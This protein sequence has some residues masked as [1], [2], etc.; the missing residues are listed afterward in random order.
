MNISR[1]VGVYAIA[2]LLAGSCIGQTFTTLAYFENG[3]YTFSSLIQGRDG[4]LYGTGNPGAAYGYGDIFKL[5]RDGTLTDLHDF[6]QQPGCTDGGYSGVSLALATDG[7]FYGSASGGTYNLG[8]IFKITPEGAYTVLHSFDG[9]DSSYPG[10]L[11]EAS[12]GNFYGTAGRTV[13]R[14]SPQGQVQTLHIFN[15]SSDGVG[16]VAPL[17]Q[18]SDGYLYGTT[19]AGGAGS[20]PSSSPP[21]GCGTVYKISTS[22]VFSVLHRFDYSDGARP[23]APVMQAGK[24]DYYGTTF[25]GAFTAFNGCPYGC[26]TVYKITSSGT[27]TVLHRFSFGDGGDTYAG[28]VQGN[29]GNLYGACPDGGNGGFGE[30]F[31]ITP[32]GKFSMLYGFST[33]SEGGG[34]TGVFQATDGKFYGTYM[35]GFFFG[36]AFSLDTGLGRFVSFVRPTGKVGQTAQILGQGLTGSTRVTF[37]GVPTT[38]FTVVSDTYMTAVVPSGASTGPVVVT[39]PGGPLTSN[40]NFRI[41][42]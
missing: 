16:P 9:T 12:D 36:A 35:A 30:I 2:F 21:Q 40:V 18:G 39:T 41:S 4:N 20:C 31:Q 42:Q 23:Y 17:I 37:N 34:A 28:L 5:S 24:G 11:I 33:M 26:G 32:A 14:M 29:D 10:A 19:Y 27:L 1:L 38:S 22:G 3:V 25:E 8:V 6:C 7:N 13:F 15:P